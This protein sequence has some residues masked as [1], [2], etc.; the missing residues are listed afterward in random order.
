MNSNE[1]LTLIA[2]DLTKE[3]PRSLN[4]SSK[5]I[6]KYHEFQRKTDIDR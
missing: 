5:E 4:P 6:F 3:F 2:K 1:K